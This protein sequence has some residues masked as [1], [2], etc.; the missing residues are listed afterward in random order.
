MGL[1]KKINQTMYKLYTNSP[2]HFFFYT[3]KMTADYCGFPV[4]VV[5]TTAEDVKA[6]KG[7]AKFPFLETPDGKTVAESTAIAGYIARTAGQQAFLGQGAFEEAQVEQWISYTN[8]TITPLCRTIAGHY[9]GHSVSDDARKSAESKL[10][11]C[12]RVLNQQL[13][14]KS[15]LVGERLTLADIVA[16]NILIIAFT[17]TFDAGKNKA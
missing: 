11:N 13:T 5:V 16:F 1:L 9:W 17:F 4:Q 10:S 2:A 7:G 14:G 8:S 3:P 15:W 6:K 12:A